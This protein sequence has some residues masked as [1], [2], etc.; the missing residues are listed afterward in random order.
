[1]SELYGIRYVNGVEILADLHGHTVHV[2]GYFVDY[3]NELYRTIENDA[4][5]AENV[6]V[7]S[8]CVY[9]NNILES[10]SM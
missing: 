4:L 1:M 5:L 7:Y 2:L 9:L 8:V 6:L 10:K 3:Q